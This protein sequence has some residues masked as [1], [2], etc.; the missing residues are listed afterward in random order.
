MKFLKY[1]MTFAAAAGL[2]TACTTDIEMVQIAPIEDVVAPVLEAPA[3]AEIVMT[4]D[5]V[6]AGELDLTWSKADFGAP[7]Q[8][9]YA[10]K[11]ASADGNKV[12]DL[13]TGVTTTA[14]TVTYSQLNAFV[15]Y[16]LEELPGVATALTLQV[17]AAVGDVVVTSNKVDLTVTATEAEKTYPFIYVIGDFN[18]W[19]HGNVEKNANFLYNFNGDG[20]T[21]EGVVDF[22]A[23]AANGFKLTGGADWDHGN[24]GTGDMTVTDA[25]ATELKLWNDGGSGNI[26]N[27][28]KRFYNFSF[29]TDALV[30]KVKESYNQI[31]V[32][33]T[34]NE[35][36]ATPDVVMEFNSHKRRFW[37]DLDIAAD[38]EIKFR[39]DS[40]WTL[41]W[42]GAD[43]EAVANG[44]NIKVAPGQYRAYLYISNSN[45]LKY[46]LDTRMY[47]LEEPTSGSTSGGDSGDD[48]PGDDPVAPEKQDNLWEV[49][50]NVN[51]TS[52]SDAACYM[53][54][55]SEGVWY[56]PA[57]DVTAAA[58]GGETGEFKL[59]YNNDWGVNY[60][61]G[62]AELTL[63]APYVGAPDGGNI[64]VPVGKY[65]VAFYEADTTFYVFALDGTG[66]GVVG[67]IA[68]AGLNW[69][70]D[71]MTYEAEGMLAV[72]GLGLT[73]ADQ[74]KFREGQ[75]WSND[76]GFGGVQPNVV[77]DAAAGG[78]NIS[79][80]EDGVYDL[81]LDLANEKIYVMKSGVNPSEA[82]TGEAEKID[83]TAHSWSLI[84]NLAGTNWDSDFDMTVEGDYVVYHNT[85][86]T[87]DQEFKIR[88]D[89]DWSLSYGVED[90]TPALVVNTTV[91]GKEN[92]ANMKVAEN[93][94]YD[95]YFNLT[96]GEISLMTPGQ[97]PAN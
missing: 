16:D 72:K 25:E 46:E 71:L 39:A 68:S 87:T 59:R 40:D 5:N 17:A 3:E 91:A 37:A 28:A 75:A 56:S 88:A 48:N 61:L 29:D 32:V 84:G 2:T 1:L 70:G 78:A 35:W 24:W 52:W 9:S 86:I 42:G 22:G 96:N 50:G 47:G 67:S 62:D 82:Q 80:S 54:Q 74:F 69:D 36:G 30:L 60:G 49:I 12:V 13:A 53:N 34:I 27:Y 19:A 64:V 89:H 20:K 95:V 73:T 10:V 7:V 58:E 18:G 76:R 8:V 6:D 77:V 44:D 94:I 92:G 38:A 41:N 55:I 90:G 85:V 11:V 33:G 15:L 14:Y 31:G 63:A 83:L 21:Y 93:G 51:G 65:Q 45:E 79:V 4:A 66:W 23:K 57:F 26:S 43:G 97:V 81:Y